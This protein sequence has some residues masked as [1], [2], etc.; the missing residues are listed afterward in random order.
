M[1]ST[2]YDGARLRT[3]SEGG[4]LEEL[5]GSHIE[6][7][8]W[9]KM[10]N[11]IIRK[12]QTWA[13]GGGARGSKYSPWIWSFGRTFGQNTNI[14]FE[15]LM[16]TPLN[17]DIISKNTITGNTYTP[18]LKEKL[19]SKMKM[20]FGNIL[21]QSAGAK[22]DIWGEG[23]KYLGEFPWYWEEAVELPHRSP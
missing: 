21:M 14:C 1:E 7:Q 13:S 20:H 12:T 11:R 19:R 8:V 2:G 23:R 22:P 6:K 9:K 4:R 17:P 10:N 15:K 5:V 16:W 18:V 3:R